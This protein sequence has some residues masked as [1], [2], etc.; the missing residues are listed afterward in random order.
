M[1]FVASNTLNFAKFIYF[2]EILSVSELLSVNNF[3]CKRFS[4]KMIFKII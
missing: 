4:K 1:W 2:K 3:N